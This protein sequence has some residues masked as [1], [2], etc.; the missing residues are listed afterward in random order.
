MTKFLGLVFALWVPAALAAAPS[1]VPKAATK[2]KAPAP[3]SASSPSPKAPIKFNFT[4]RKD[5]VG[6]RIKGKGDS[7]MMNPSG[8]N[9]SARPR[10]AAPSGPTSFTL[11]QPA[12][13][14]GE[15]VLSFKT[16]DADLTLDRKSPMVV[17]VFAEAPL[18]V[19]PSVITMSRWPKTGDSLELAIKAQADPSGSTLQGKATYRVCSKKSGKC[20]RV[21]PQFLSLVVRQ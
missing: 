1:L 20:E 19:V 12:D 17:Q 10:K 2:A 5:P 4:P 16:S 11:S 9:P 18:Q 8:L 21:G 13:K 6:S 15:V 3:T 7:K 14:K